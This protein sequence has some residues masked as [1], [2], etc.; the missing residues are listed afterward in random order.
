[1]LALV[2]LNIIIYAAD[3]VPG[4]EIQEES[5]C[6]SLHAIIIIMDNNNIVTNKVFHLLWQRHLMNNFQNSEQQFQIKE[7]FCSNYSSFICDIKIKIL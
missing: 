3:K 6:Y 1:M 5:F 4:G 2:I 7:I